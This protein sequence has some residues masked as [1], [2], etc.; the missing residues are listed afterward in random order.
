MRK[1]ER[2]EG[3][4]YYPD[5]NK[6]YVVRWYDLARLCHDTNGDL[7]FKAGRERRQVHYHLR[8]NIKPEGKNGYV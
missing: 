5:F 8:A 3:V 1:D 2:V 6:L 4:R 7:C